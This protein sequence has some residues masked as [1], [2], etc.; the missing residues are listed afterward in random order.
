MRSSTKTLVSSQSP[1]G[2]R[3]VSSRIQRQTRSEHECDNDPSLAGCPAPPPY[4]LA[5]RISGDDIYVAY[6]RS[7]WQGSSSHYYRF[8]LHR[9]SSRNG[10]Y[11]RSASVYDSI[12]PAIFS[13]PSSGYWYKS[14]AQRCRYSNRTSCGNWSSFSSVIEI[15]E[16]SLGLPPAPS[17]FIRPSH[18]L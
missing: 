8:E 16:T 13:N 5:I 4:N 15:E 14:R 3:R 1:S 6:T 7:S 12:S 17:N 11:R 9:A 18:W 2:N 10:S